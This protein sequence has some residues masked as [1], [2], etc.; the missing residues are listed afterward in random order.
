MTFKPAPKTR[1]VDLLVFLHGVGSSGGDLAPLGEMWGPRLG[2]AFAA[3]DAPYPFDQAAVGR[4][5]FSVLGV[6]PGNR[7][8]RVE[9]AAGAFD[10]TVDAAIRAAGT[11]AERTVLVGFSQGTIMALDALVRGRHFAGVLGFSG[12][13]ARPPMGSLEGKPILL[14][15]GDADGVIPIG[16]AISARHI[17]AEAGAEVD[18]ARI[19]G[20][21]HGIGPAAAAVGFGFL[22][23]LVAVEEIGEDEADEA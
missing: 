19:A 7:V 5:W 23:R 12:R 6:T 15:H 13:L 9:A 14:V 2:V 22:E 17:L 11:T 10:A 1:A 20:E 16:E 8:E 21:G 4:Q 18:F 3:P